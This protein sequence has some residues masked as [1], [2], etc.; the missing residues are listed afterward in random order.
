MQTTLMLVIYFL[1]RKLL[2][3]QTSVLLLTNS[4]ILSLRLLFSCCTNN[5]RKSCATG[6]LGIS[7]VKENDNKPGSS[8]SNVP[9]I[10]IDSRTYNNQSGKTARE[11][12]T[13]LCKVF[14]NPVSESH[15][16][17]WWVFTFLSTV[18]VSLLVVVWVAKSDGTTF[19]MYMPGSAD[20]YVS[21]SGI[22]LSVFYGINSRS[23]NPTGDEVLRL[24]REG[25]LND[26]NENE[27]DDV[28]EPPKPQSTKAKEEIGGIG[29]GNDIGPASDRGSLLL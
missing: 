11:H 28:E 26:E 13:T 3:T 19:F 12:I 16:F 23:Q 1:P 25:G 6:P 22:I 20:N 17:P 5:F 27:D 2:P 8:Y 10:W 4:T 15:T 18:A 29:D 24:W 14:N 9:S 7:L 21:V